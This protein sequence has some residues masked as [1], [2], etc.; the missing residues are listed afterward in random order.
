[1]GTVDAE[2]SP[3][4]QDIQKLKNRVFFLESEVRNLNT[5]VKHLVEA[6]EK[7]PEKSV[8]S[9]VSTI[10]KFEDFV[11]T[12]GGECLRPPV[13]QFIRRVKPYCGF[14]QGTGVLHRYG[15]DVAACPKCVERIPES[16]LEESC[17]ACDEGMLGGH[18]CPT[19]PP[20][21]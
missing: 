11:M 13:H 14:C 20:R 16:V 18:T 17:K 5:I 12:Y 9:G 7:E 4:N 2:K 10:E 15:Q 3:M 21:S 6:R 8:S 19:D 1:M